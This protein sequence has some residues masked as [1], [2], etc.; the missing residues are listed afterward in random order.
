MENSVQ[1]K[2]DSSLK[3]EIRSD[4]KVKFFSF[5]SA[6]I[7]SKQ[8]KPAN[9]HLPHHNGSQIKPEMTKTSQKGF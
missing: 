8:L 1:N 5:Y 6:C 4:E 2:F 3:N 7:I 9:K